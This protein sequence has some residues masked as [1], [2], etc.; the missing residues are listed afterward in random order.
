[1]TTSRCSS[2]SI[3]NFMRPVTFGEAN[4]RPVDLAQSTRIVFRTEHLELKWS[5]CSN[6]ADFLSQYYAGVLA[7]NRTASQVRDLTHSIA[8]M[9][10]ELIEN[11]VKFRAAG[12]I[13]LTAGIDSGTFVLR[14]TNWISPETGERFQSLLRD[15]TSGDPGELLIRRIE[16]NAASGGSGSGLGLLTLMNDYGVRLSWRFEPS[17]DPADNRI[18][19]ETLARLKLPSEQP[20]TTS[21]RKHGN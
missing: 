19:I 2:S 15:I 4:D 16:E 13:E 8:Y 11:A 17:K 9:A 18:F 10:N 20:A 1:M 12:D 3:S 6:S 7:Q 21:K 5:Y 14:I